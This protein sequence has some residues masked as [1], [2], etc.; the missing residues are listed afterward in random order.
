MADFKLLFQPGKIGPL[1]I[2]NRIVMSPMAMPLGDGNG[3]VTQKLTDHFAE[4][5]KGGV[6]L[7]V[8]QVTPVMA[9][10]RA[11]KFYMDVWDDKFIPGLK[12]FVDAIHSNGAK[13][14]LQVAHIGN[15]MGDPRRLA[16]FGPGEEQV[17]VGPSAIPYVRSGMMAKALTIPEI[18]EIVEAF[19]EGARRTKEAGFDAVHIHGAHGK[20][21]CQF[22]NPFYNKRTDEYGGSLENRAR[23]GCEI[24]ASIRKRVGPDYPVIMRMDGWD[25]YEGSLTPPEAIEIAKMYVKVGVTALDV[26]AGANEGSHWQFLPYMQESGALVRYAEG[27]KKVVKVPVMTVGKIGDPALAEKILR[28]GKADFIDLGRSL[29]AD[30][31]WPEKVRTGRLDDVQWC[32]FCNN[33]LHRTYTL[34]PL[35][36]TVN[37]ALARD[38]EYQDKLKPVAAPKKVMV[39]GGGLAGMEAALVAAQ[40]G[41]QVTLYEKADKLGGQWNV[42]CMEKDKSFFS[43]VTQLIERRLQQAK[44]KVVL[45]TEVTAAT[46]KESH[47][48]ALVVATGA[49]PATLDVPGAS[50]ANVVQAVDVITKKAK[51]GKQVVV[52]GG[53]Y[54]GMEVALDLAREGKKVSLVTRREVGRDVEY[55]TFMALRERLIQQGVPFYPN[56]NVI[57][58]RQNGISLITNHTLLM[59]PAETIVL[60]VGYVS[61]NKLAEELKGAAPEVYSVGDCVQPRDGLAAVNEGADAGLKI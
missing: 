12:G 35:S 3:F 40:R 15:S 18:H 55:N 33:C 31:Y 56:C 5:A 10:C 36:C 53:R 14:A 42:A 6:G 13:V 45:K 24:I 8:T 4:R 39:I 41:H 51:V 23:L 43:T 46:V 47:P 11:S 25:G 59:L 57:E 50:G 19:G 22:H 9:N 28:D 1:E 16:P 21:I 61:E 26:S 17:V 30:P 37:P 2:K 58:I 7:I 34:K 49:R 20:I 48:D 54:V 52:V 44:V 27:I 38:Q 32:I 29:L 60:A